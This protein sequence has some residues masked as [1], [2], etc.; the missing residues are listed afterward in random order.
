M[1]SYL[2]S[3]LPRTYFANLLIQAPDSDETANMVSLVTM[4]EYDDMKFLV[5]DGSKKLREAS[6]LGEDALF[7]INRSRSGVPSGPSLISPRKR[8]SPNYVAT[9]RA[10]GVHTPNKTRSMGLPQ[11][12]PPKLKGHPRDRPSARKLEDKTRLRDYHD[13]SDRR[14]GGFDGDW[15]GALSFSRGFH[16]IWNCGGTG[17]DTGT[18]SPTQVVTPKDVK[19][20]QM[21]VAA[22]NNYRPM[23]EGRDT[24]HGQ[25][26]DGAMAAR[27]N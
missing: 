19:S 10:P 25:T 18:I 6:A 4:G 2:L 14:N 5:R 3:I 26:R 20:H 24:A 7:A 22:G 12:A 1:I 16:S 23:F 17:E 8:V 13:E 21:G 11:T 15:G 9:Q 27:A